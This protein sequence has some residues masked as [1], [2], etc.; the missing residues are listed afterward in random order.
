VHELLLHLLAAIVPAVVVVEVECTCWCEDVIES[1]QVLLLLTW[2]EHLLLSG[3]VKA[4]A[5]RHKAAAAQ[6]L[7]LL[8]PAWS[9]HL[10]HPV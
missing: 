10:L 1:V 3:Q 7:L 6:V 8:L 9:Q 4:V 5:K 2:S